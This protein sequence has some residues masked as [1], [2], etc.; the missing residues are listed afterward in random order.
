D[1]RADQAARDAFMGFVID[2]AV[3]AIPVGGDFAAKAI[4]DRVSDALGGL[5]EQVRNTIAD[6][7]AAIPKELLTNAQG[8]L[9]D[10]AK[11]AIIESLPEDYQY[12]E[13][14]KEDTNGFIENTIIGSS[15]RDYQITES[16]SD[17][18]DYI[19]NS[20]GG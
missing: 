12:L 11:A 2:V 18:R 1:L 5:S 4:T 13:G 8:E 6:S 16:M 9:T 3:S 20:K 10:Q 7:L 19:D 14:I 17:Y 15:V